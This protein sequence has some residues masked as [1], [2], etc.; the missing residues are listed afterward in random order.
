MK[1]ISGRIE[2]R[3]DSRTRSFSEKQFEATHSS[4]VQPSEEAITGRTRQP[5]G[6]H[7][8]WRKLG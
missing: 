4:F 2:L 1:L 8:G 7:T 5:G 3:E 6:G